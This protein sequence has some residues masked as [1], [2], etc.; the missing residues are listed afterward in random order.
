MILYI[1]KYYNVK[2]SENGLYIDINS[3]LYI[4]SKYTEHSAYRAKIISIY[5]NPTLLL[6]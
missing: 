2:W 5:S 3:F 4:E 6:F 1:L